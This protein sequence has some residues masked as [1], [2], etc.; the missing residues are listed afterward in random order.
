[1][2]FKKKKFK[3]MVKRKEIE[4]KKKDK[5]FKAF[6]KGLFVSFSED[7]PIAKLYFSPS[8]ELFSF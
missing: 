1:M 8:G 4:I 6:E 7:E 3:K 2:L 5:L